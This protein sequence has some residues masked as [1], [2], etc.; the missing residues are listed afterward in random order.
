[1]D[2]PALD[3][4]RQAALAELRAR[5][6]TERG[7]RAC[8]E[9]LLRAA[10]DAGESDL[11]VLTAGALVARGLAGEEAR[12][13][14][15]SHRPGGLA[16][17]RAPLDET[18]WARIRHPDDD[19]DISTIFEHADG[20]A[21]AE[22]GDTALDPR[23]GGTPIAADDLPTTFRD[24]LDRAAGVLG[25]ERPVVLERP[26]LADRTVS[27]LS[28]APL[29]LAGPEALRST[30]ALSLAFTLG[31]TLSYLKRGRCV[32]GACPWWLLNKVLFAYLS[33]LRP[34]RPTPPEKL[35]A[36]VRAWLDAQPDAVTQALRDAISA[37]KARWKSV[38]LSR[39]QFAMARTADRVGLLLSGDVVLAARLA[40]AYRPADTIDSLVDF[41]LD[42]AHLE[43]RAA[44]GLSV[45]DAA[46]SAVA[47]DPPPSPDS[48]S[49]PDIVE[50]ADRVLVEDA[51]PS[52]VAADPPPRPDSASRRGMVERADRVRVE[53]EVSL[54][55]DHNFYLGLTENLSEGGLF[56][57]THKP[58]P[59][60][61]LVELRFRVPGYDTVVEA[62]GEVRWVRMDGG[63]RDAVPGMGVRFRRLE[64]GD[65]ARVTAFLRNREA[66]FFDE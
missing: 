47:A 13:L 10:L 39:W 51:A 18:V 66:I 59:I 36:G 20:L 26:D 65:A 25:V 46:P 3:D 29:I 23:R 24:V 52:A 50:K 17:L 21:L 37:V 4:T 1:M 44:L 22:I 28:E 32:G 2:V 8:G 40:A 41:A 54:E 57:A 55:S 6:R 42:T 49:R 33:G 62:E 56:V 9:Q 63:G 53:I 19:P 58:L 61:A 38:E 5:W 31:R 7:D 43:T 48:A 14:H 60:G 64:P 11:A 45:G 12:A 35:G 27:A 30:D 16:V 15:E 34:G